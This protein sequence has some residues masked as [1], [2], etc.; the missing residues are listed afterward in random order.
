[1]RSRCCPCVCLYI[2][3][4]GARQRLDKSPLVVARQRLHFLCVPCRLKRKQAIKLFVPF[5]TQSSISL[6]TNGIVVIHL[7]WI[8]LESQKMEEKPT[9]PKLLWIHFNVTKFLLNSSVKISQLAESG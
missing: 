1:M 4:I 3:H 5:C 8:Q 2:P 9:E 7:T 6:Q